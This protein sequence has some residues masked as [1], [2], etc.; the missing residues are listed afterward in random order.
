MWSKVELLSSYFK[1]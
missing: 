1:W